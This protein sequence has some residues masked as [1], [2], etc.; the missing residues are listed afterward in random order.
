MDLFLHN[1]IGRNGMFVR[2][3]KKCLNDYISLRCKC[4]IIMVS[5]DKKHNNR[6]FK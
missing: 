4:V 2:N 3:Y 6:I 5:Y 1:T